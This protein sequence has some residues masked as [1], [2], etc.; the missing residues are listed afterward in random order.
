MTPDQFEY[1]L[2]YLSGVAEALISHREEI[3]A[4]EKRVETLEGY[5]DDEMHKR[6]DQ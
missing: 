6:K 5:H 4:L 2:N 1:I 3:D